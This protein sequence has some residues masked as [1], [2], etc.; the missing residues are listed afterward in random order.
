MK[1]FL[2]GDLYIHNLYYLWVMSYGYISFRLISYYITILTLYVTSVLYIKYKRTN[3][4]MKTK[5]QINF[6]VLNL[7]KLE[8]HNHLYWYILLH[9]VYYIKYYLFVYLMIKKKQYFTKIKLSVSYSYIT[10]SSIQEGILPML[11]Y[12]VK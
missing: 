4:F 8:T 2:I 10:R 7:K 9:Q 11:F 6:Y 3:W 5:L 1:T 12:M